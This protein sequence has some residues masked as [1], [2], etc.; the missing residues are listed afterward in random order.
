MASERQLD[1]ATGVGRDEGEP[2]GSQRA[3]DL[4]REQ[5]RDEVAVVVAR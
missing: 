5:R 1:A 3:G 2:A 4:G